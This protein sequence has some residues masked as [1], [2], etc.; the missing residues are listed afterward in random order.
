MACILFL[1]PRSSCMSTS[2]AA[3]VNCEVVIARTPCHTK[4]TYRL[5]T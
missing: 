5:Q 4:R 1:R 3:S 2:F